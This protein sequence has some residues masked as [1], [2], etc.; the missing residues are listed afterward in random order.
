LRSHELLEVCV[1]LPFYIL[2]FYVEICASVGMD[3]SS[4]LTRVLL[5]EQLSLEGSILNSTQREENKPPSQQ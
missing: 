2:L 1:A 3:S 4:D 5:S